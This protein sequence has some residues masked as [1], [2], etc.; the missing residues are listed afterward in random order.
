MEKLTEGNTI[1][2]QKDSRKMM[3]NE[4]KTYGGFAKINSF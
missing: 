1:K 3:L 4:L 2:H